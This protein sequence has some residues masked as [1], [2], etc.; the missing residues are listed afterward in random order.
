MLPDTLLGV[1]TVRIE[2]VYRPDVYAC[3]AGDTL[4]Q[5]A[6]QMYRRD[7]GVLAISGDGRLTGVISER[8][9]VRAVAGGADM[10]TAT[11]G[12]YASR[13]VQVCALDN[14]SREVAQRM[15]AAGMRHMPVVRDEYLAGVVSMRDLL[16]VEVWV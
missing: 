11:A 5:V 2:D 8:D 10:T 6:Q 3:T 9:L 4:Q 7:V 16:A 13:D 12:D 14:D 15:L 1:S